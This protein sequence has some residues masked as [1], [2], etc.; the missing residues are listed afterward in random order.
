MESYKRARTTERRQETTRFRVEETINFKD[1]AHAL[2][3]DSLYAGAATTLS[4]VPCIDGRDLPVPLTKIR[5]GQI[6]LCST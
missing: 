2:R 6:S 5:Y 4:S 3:L 1:T